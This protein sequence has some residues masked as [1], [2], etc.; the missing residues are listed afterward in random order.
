MKTI[1]MPKSFLLKDGSMRNT[2][3][4]LSKLIETKNKEIAIDFSEIQELEKGDLMVLFAQMEKSIITHR[5]KL[6]RKGRLPSEKKIKTTLLSADKI[7]HINKAI[8]IPEISDAEKEK[9]LSPRLVDDIVKDLKKIGIKEYYYPFNVFLTELIGNAVEHGI[10]NKNINWWLTHE[11]DRKNRIVKYTFVDMGMGII[12]SHKKAKLP[13]KY[14]FFSDKRIVLDA[15]F[16]KLGS[17]TKMSYRGRGLPQLREMIENGLVANLTLITNNVSL[18]FQNGVFIANKNPNF[19]GT[20]Y[21]WTIDQN[22]FQK[23]KNSQLI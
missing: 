16:G 5:N 20:Y 11:I 18:N 17:S 7:F 21:S 9:L 15:L 2:I 13:I 6:F 10:E 3:L 1:K 4:T 12:N 23:W 14:Y 8:E 22:N 19:V